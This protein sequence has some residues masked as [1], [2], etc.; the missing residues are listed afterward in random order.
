MLTK[1]ERDIKTDI[2]DDLDTIDRAIE[3]QKVSK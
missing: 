3:R 1:T 2:E